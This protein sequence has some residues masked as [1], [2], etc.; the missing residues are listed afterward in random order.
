MLNN[1]AG[2]VGSREIGT[3]NPGDIKVSIGFASTSNFYYP[4]LLGEPDAEGEFNV[5][6]PAGVTVPE[7]SIDAWIS[8]VDHFGQGYLSMV[9]YDPETSTGVFK[10]SVK[11]DSG[12]YIMPDSNVPIYTQETEFDFIIKVSGS[13][14]IDNTSTSLTCD[15]P[16]RVRYL[17]GSAYLDDESSN[18]SRMD[19]KYTGLFAGT[20]VKDNKNSAAVLFPSLV[21][22][23]TNLKKL[24]MP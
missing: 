10:T 17:P 14:M 7:A 16:V 6:F 1:S 21:T 2:R 20:T 24:V 19:T 5:S 13:A 12:A 4:A 3:L 8:E 11:N 9:S 15:I 23:P 22:M 18:I